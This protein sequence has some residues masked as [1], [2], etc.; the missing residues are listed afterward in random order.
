MLTGVISKIYK[1]LCMQM[2]YS[3]VHAAQSISEI[4]YLIYTDT[5]YRVGL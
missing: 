3:K 2:T 1:G 5:E 4:A